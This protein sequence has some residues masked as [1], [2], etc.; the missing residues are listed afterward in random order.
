MS[1][2]AE[3]DPGRALG[4]WAPQPTARPA[5][6]DGGPSAH[7]PVLL[8]RQ[9]ECAAIDGMLSAAQDGRGGT[10]VL[11][12]EPGVGKT[13][14]LDYAVGQA[15]GLLV[16]RV[17]AA[18]AEMGLAFAALH[19]ML[20]PLLDRLS[21]LPER[22]RSALRQVL[23][24]DGGAPPTRSL[25]SLAV[26][27]LIR[28]TAV[29]QPTLLIADDTQF[30]DAESA[31][32]LAF[33]AR[34]L[35][36]DA[37]AC[38][39]TVPELASRTVPFDGLP[40]R[41][42]RS[43]PEPESRE[44]FL[45]LVGGLPDE[46]LVGR[47]VAEMGGNPLA[48]AGVAGEVAAGRLTVGSLSPGPLPIG[49]RLTE[50]FLGP[51]RELPEGSRTLLLLTAAEPFVDRNL[52]WRAAARL[53]LDHAASGPA[54]AS[55]L[56]VF[57]PEI[58]LHP[59]VR[60]A[61]YHG[62]PAEERRRMHGALAEVLDLGPEA[63][64][65]A[66]HRSAAVARPDEQIASELERS[67]ERAWV[68]SGY[69]ACGALL[70]RA[71]ELTPQRGRR[72]ERMIAAAA[73]ELSAGAFARARELLEQADPHLA[74]PAAQARARALDGR[75]RFALGQAGEAAAILLRAARDL[76]PHDPLRARAV[77]LEAL[78][79]ALYAGS[80]ATGAGDA[81]IVSAAAAAAAQAPPETMTDRLLAG[82]AAVLTGDR[83]AGLPLLRR[84]IGDLLDGVEPGTAAPGTPSTRET[85]TP[86]V[87]W[88]TLACCAA[89]ELLDDHA[90]HALANRCVRLARDAGDF[91]ELPRALRLLGMTELV[92]GHFCAA[93]ACR[94]EELKVSNATGY[95]GILGTAAHTDALVLAWRGRESETRAAADQLAHDGAERGRGFAFSLSLCALATLELG[96]G[97]YQEA[98]AHGLDLYQ[99]DAFLH[100]TLAL[101][102]LIEAAV[103]AGDRLV[104][105]AALDRFTGRAQASGTPWASGLLAQSRALLASDTAAEPLYREAIGQ[106]RETRAA[107]DLA[108]AHLLYG[109]W[110]RRQRRRR[111]ARAELRTACEMLNS[112]GA[113]AF[114]AR[115]EG[116]LRAT[117]ERAQRGSADSA[118][119]TPQ[120]AQIAALVAQGASNREVAEQLFISVCTVECHLRKA[121]RK[122]GVSSRAKLVRAL[123]R[124]DQPVQLPVAQV[125]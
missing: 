57:E 31:Q 101:P 77:M 110:L 11:R 75:I 50:R 102:G 95:W 17:S 81:E 48:L 109:E 3:R 59:L 93:E 97:R 61:V 47:V 22:Q 10:L 53:G 96:L 45:W 119:L 69:A 62:A 36:A 99:E 39:F 87:R 41:C 30:L 123:E 121:F 66:W 105:S 52:I 35:S 19:Q 2:T 7:E 15:P 90:W 114:A 38:L 51:V 80:T 18:E 117:A 23:G 32:V 111:D 21:E 56:A 6:A 58:L 8:G 71:G 27:T 4:A 118:V 68:R 91:A 78:E 76:Q 64:R 70:A 43:L 113:G 104:A 92:S 85:G 94:A 42:V 60:S 74:Q 122:L 26:L 28:Q 83:A 106:L 5:S 40:S 33:V 29:G 107:P 37:V 120:E 124:H 46:L 13:A 24:L 88:L 100:G 55:R 103:R 1:S 73:A 115:A 108:R 89:G 67:A 98:M 72:A 116:E 34:R 84:I 20:L 14:L 25:V 86:A 112:M 12:G 65:R 9:S 16:L 125:G 79:A 63:D 44:L 49:Q 54:V 82:Y